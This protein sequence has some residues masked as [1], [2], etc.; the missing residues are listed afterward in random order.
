MTEGI[1]KSAALTTENCGVFNHWNAP[2][3][4]L[5]KSARYVQQP[6]DK[7]A[8]LVDLFSTTKNGGMDIQT[9]NN[10]EYCIGWQLLYLVEHPTHSSHVPKIVK[11]EAEARIRAMWRSNKRTAN[12]FNAN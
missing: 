9:S 2:S 8:G 3:S 11:S 5:S 1:P 4:G 10:A 6:S 12:L 7:V